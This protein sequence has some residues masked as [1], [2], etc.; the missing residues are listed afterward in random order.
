MT[1]KPL[2]LAVLLPLVG[3]T[4]VPSLLHAMPPR[5]APRERALLGIWQLKTR[6]LARAT[7]VGQSS[8]NPAPTQAGIT[9]AYTLEPQ[10]EIQVAVERSD[11]RLESVT[12]SNALSVGHLKQQDNLRLRFRI[13]AQSPQELTLQLRETAQ[14]RWSA[15]VFAT[16]EWHDVS[17]PVSFET[18]QAD[19]AILAIQLGESVGTLTLAELRVEPTR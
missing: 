3:L 8:A 4:L 12:L 16:Q 14:V 13:R 7:P 2:P 11:P 10:E 18:F 17:L 9:S 5:H 1:I 6:H 19:H 15:R